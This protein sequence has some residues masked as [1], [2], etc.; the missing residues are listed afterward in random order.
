MIY[1]LVSAGASA[2]VSALGASEAGSAA[3]A[4]AVGSASE[5]VQRVWNGLA[6]VLSS[7]DMSEAYQVVPEELHNEGRVLV[8]L[9]RQG[10]ELCLGVSAICTPF[11]VST[12]Q[13]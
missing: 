4:S 11:D 8:A 3:G 5:E 13:Q 2:L 6:L 12:H 10:V 1:A 9:L 7:K